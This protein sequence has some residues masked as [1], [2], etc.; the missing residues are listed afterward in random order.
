MRVFVGVTAGSELRTRIE[1]VRLA[2]E[3]EIA[4]RAREAPRIVWV[5]P[6]AL[7]VTL[8]FLG[9][10]PDPAV[11]ALCEAVAA[12]YPMPPFTVRWHGLGAFPSPRRP[13]ALW[14]GVADGAR[15][16][17]ALEQAVASR[18]GRAA[19]GDESPAFRPHVTIG[20]VKTEGRDVPWAAAL[21]AADVAGVSQRV[22]HVSVFRSRGL[23]GGEGYEEIA[24]G[25]LEG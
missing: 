12:L 15:E 10:V 24:R 1:E 2:V 21:A 13:R 20:R 22:S 5:K 7:H 23:P 14:I 16:L 25:A 8:A 3:A 11:A 6:A 19:A 4:Q 17:A 9:E 18:L